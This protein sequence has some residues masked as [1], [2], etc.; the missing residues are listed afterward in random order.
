M[1]L[2]LYGALILYTSITLVLFFSLEDSLYECDP[3]R[4]EQN[5]DCNYNLLVSKILVF[6][7]WMSLIAS[8]YISLAK[9]N[10]RRIDN[11]LEVYRR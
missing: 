1:E 11:I 8:V 9:D 6:S 2:S 4:C 5:C 3:L 7:F 10:R